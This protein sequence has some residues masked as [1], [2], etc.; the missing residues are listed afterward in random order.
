MRPTAVSPGAPNRTLR[1]DMLGRSLPRP[2]HC[3]MSGSPAVLSAVR[4]NG[5]QASSPWSG[6]TPTC[7]CLPPGAELFVLTRSE[8]RFSHLEGQRGMVT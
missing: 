5:P 7:L 3:G 1:P 4:E 8:L 2:P 6:C